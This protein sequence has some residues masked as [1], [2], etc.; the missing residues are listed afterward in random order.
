[1]PNSYWA[2]ILDVDDSDEVI[3][4]GYT[5][6]D[7]NICD[8]YLHAT[9]VS[10]N[11]GLVPLPSVWRISLKKHQQFLGRYAI[12]TQIP[13]EPTETIEDLYQN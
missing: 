13:F 7:K 12:P 1:M 6:Q 8:A 10:R 5:F 9:E 11:T 3:V 4:Y 2:E